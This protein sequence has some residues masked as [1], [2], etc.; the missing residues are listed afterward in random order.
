MTPA[1]KD[2]VAPLTLATLSKNKVLSYLADEDTW[3]NHVYV[4]PLG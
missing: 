4:G 2:F 3:A 1:A